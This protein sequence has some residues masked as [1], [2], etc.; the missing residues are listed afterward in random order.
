MK[1]GFQ[2]DTN[3]VL[4]QHLDSAGQVQYRI[5]KRI[6]QTGKSAEH[7]L[8]TRAM[9]S[10]LR[11][12]N[13]DFEYVFFDDRQ[14]EAFIDG[15]FPQYR[16]IFNS[17]PF[18]I[19]RYDFF[20][21]LAVYRHGGFYFDL[22]V[23]LASGLLS[24]LEYGC[25]FPF[26]GLTLSPYLRDSYKMDWEIG[27]YAFGAAAGHPFLE[28]VIENCVKAQRDPDWVNPMMRGLPW[29]FRSEF[30]ILN[31]TGPGLISRT[32]AENADLAKTVKV[33]FPDDVCDVANWNRFG[34]LGV[35]IMEGSWRT[36]GGYIHRR[37]AQRWEHWTMQRLLKQSRALGKTR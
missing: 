27:N 2:S 14:V 15:E 26:E 29:L 30:L 1:T 16:K 34:D 20:R 22:D 35:H 31:T 10:N 33:L 8:R 24:L 4:E 36:R 25:V 28:T 17:F 3:S 18:R 13:P 11:L 32:L 12:L 9:V 7:S 23:M 6:I 19:Q 37:L 5:P 21:Y